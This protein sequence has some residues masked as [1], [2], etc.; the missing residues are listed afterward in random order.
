MM[1]IDGRYYLGHLEGAGKVWFSDLWKVLPSV[2]LFV[3]MM[4]WLNRFRGFYLIC[5]NLNSSKIAFV[6]ILLPWVNKIPDK[7]SKSLKQMSN[8]G[9]FSKIGRKNHYLEILKS[10]MGRR[11]H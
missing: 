7:N 10:K 11:N 9:S 1:K 8:Y 2:L 3:T 4:T 5:R 6:P